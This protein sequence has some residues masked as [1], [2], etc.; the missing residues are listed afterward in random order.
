M[1]TGKIPLIHRGLYA[2]LILSLVLPGL[3]PPSRALQVEGMRIIMDVQP[4]KTYIFPMAVSISGSEAPMDVAIDVVGLGNYPG[5]SLKEVSP[6]DDRGA[7]SA[8]PF[9]NVSAAAVHLKPGGR[10]PFNAT[11]RVP[12]NTGNGGRYAGILIHQLPGPGT[13]SGAGVTTALLAS[14]LLTVQGS[15]LTHTGSITDLQVGKVVSGMPVEVRTTLRNSGNHHYSGTLVNVTVSDAAGKV[16]ATGSAPPLLF[17]L[18]PG[19]EVT[20][21]APLSAPL[22]PGSYTV[23]SEARIAEGAVPLDSRTAPLTITEPYVPPFQESSADL[24]P[25]R[26]AILATPGGEVTVRFPRGS[27]ISPVHVTVKPPMG[28][29]PEA[30]VPAKAGT[31]A[32][33]LEGITGLL[34]MDAT[35]VVKYTADDLKAAEGDPSRLSLARWDAD[36]SRWTLLPTTVDQGERT[37]T[38]GTNRLG[39]MEVLG[40]PPPGAA[41]T[42]GR[43]PGPDAI[44]TVS[45]ASAAL[46][47]LGRRR[48]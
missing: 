39:I 41:A 48:R 43:I 21:T 24:V 3:V 4:G 25:E 15:N 26:E 13:Q 17:S 46:L 12:R 28:T 2:I 18:I 42:P 34:T 47:F 44:A 19:N 14:V 40:S 38:A 9:I 23:K 30:P 37:L 16:V 6:A 5:G 31:T 36:K 7:Y 1:Q 29:L 22:A 27:V 32:L 10:F 11:I 33:T 35:V 45:V 8:R 20:L